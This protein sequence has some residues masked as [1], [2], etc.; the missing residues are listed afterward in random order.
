M[1]M[2]NNSADMRTW[3]FINN[4]RELIGLLSS[5][6][7]GRNRRGEE[8][9]ALLFASLLFLRKHDLLRII[10]AECYVESKDYCIV[11]L[12]DSQY[13]I[14]Q[15]IVLC[16][17]R[18]FLEQITDDGFRNL[19]KKT[20]DLFG[21]VNEPLF[22]VDFVDILNKQEFKDGDLLVLLDRYL[23]ELDYMNAEIFCQPKELTTIVTSLVNK[24]VYSVFDPFGGLMNFATSMP[25]KHFVA[26][27]I[28]VKT[29]ELALFRLALAGM[30]GQTDLHENSAEYWTEDKFDAIV[31]FPPFGYRMDIR[32]NFLGFHYDADQIVLSRFGQTTYAN[33]QLII[34]VSLS[35]LFKETTT[36]RTCRENIVKNNWLDA[37]VVLPSGIYRSTQTASAIVVLKKNRKAGEAIRFV[38]ASH[39]AHREGVRNVIDVDEVMGLISKPDCE[40]SIEV[41]IEDVLKQGSSWHVGWYLYQRNAN[42]RIGYKQ[43]PFGDVLASSPSINHFDE[44]SGRLVTSEALSLSSLIR[45]EFKPED[46][47]V[48]N[49]LR[50]ARKI[51][52]PVLLISQTSITFPLYCEASE[53]NP[54]FV[55]PNIGA[56]EICADGIDVGYLCVELFHRMAGLNQ[57]APLYS[58]RKLFEKIILAFPSVAEQLSLFEDMQKT[59]IDAE[60]RRLGLED[61]IEGYKK[62]FRARKHAISQNLSAFSALWNTLYRFKNKNGGQLGD[63][64]VVSVTYNKTVADI[65]DSLNERLNVILMQ[66]EHIADDE[67]DWGEPE[68]I[69]P[70]AFIEEF[71]KTHSDIRFSYVHEGFDE[72]EYQ[73]A[74]EEMEIEYWSKIVFPKKALV[75]IFENIVS[76]AVEHG[77]T[78]PD[79]NDYKILISQQFEDIDRWTI[80]ISNNGKAISESFVPSKAFEYGY[81]TQSSNGH[82]GLGSYQVDELMKRYGGEVELISTPNEFYTVTYVLTFKKLNIE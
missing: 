68:E 3:E 28:N 54:I 11:C 61:E 1:T 75:R 49:D 12:D 65:F 72:Q 41:T 19:L 16:C 15:P 17:D 70:D 38:D 59:S 31:T 56:Y 51:I 55:K 80:R 18:G 35:T 64:D 20:L 5:A 77:F 44:T 23:E 79:R 4:Y 32:D 26:Y 27:E 57:Y 39:C 81:T 82:T 34:V 73:K 63:T 29:R 62:Q 36:I 78:E 67:P 14:Q 71:I 10:K 48:S 9:I 7:Q 58:N 50:N 33:G 25:D 60:R 76:N 6:F 52:N 45:F 24:D 66:V 46:F 2:E 21:E 43:V 42:Y 8:E 47:V 22:I 69:E 40:H 30:V 74:L 13:S 37:V 53:N